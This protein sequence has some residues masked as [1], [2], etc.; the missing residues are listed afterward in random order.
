MYLTINHSL[1]QSVD[2]DSPSLWR[3]LDEGIRWY[4][5]DVPVSIHEVVVE[6][7]GY[8]I[9]LAHFNAKIC[10]INVRDHPENGRS[11]RVVAL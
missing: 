5:F 1:P 3:R 11:E 6:W 2:A 9:G 4:V 7:T 8:S 10:A